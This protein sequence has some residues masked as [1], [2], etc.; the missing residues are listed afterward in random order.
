MA[1]ARQ[2]EMKDNITVVATTTL[3]AA[4]RV[5]ELSQ[6]SWMGELKAP[7]DDRP[8]AHLPG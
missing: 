2:K 4:G 6:C 3:T 7:S 5:S 1:A 8:M